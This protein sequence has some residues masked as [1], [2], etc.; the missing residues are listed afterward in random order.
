MFFKKYSPV[1]LLCVLCMGCNK[2][3]KQLQQVMALQQMNDLA[4]VEYVVTKIIKA[5]DNKTWY[6]IGDRKILM[7]CKATLTAGID[8]SAI[9]PEQVN[10]DG[11]HITLTLPHSKMISVN[12][13]PE[14]I[15]EAYEAVDVLR[16]SFTSEERNGL[17]IQA[18]QQI[19]ASIGE[20]G[21]LQTAETNAALFVNN[22]LHQLGYETI[23]INFDNLATP[24]N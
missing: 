14:D 7:S 20:L 19:N 8:L 21:I 17:A 24:K 2:K 11:K 22:F 16:Q 4:T 1:L 15:T 10:I 13:K 12:I 23:K 9:K 5:N 18:E 6:K 3:E